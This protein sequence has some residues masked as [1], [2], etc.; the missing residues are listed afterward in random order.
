[1]PELKPTRA[2]GVRPR[3][4]L[5]VIALIVVV[6]ALVALVLLR[7]QGGVKLAGFSRESTATVSYAGKFPGPDDA[8]LLNPLGITVRGTTLYVAESD[9]ARIRVFGLQGEARGSIAVPVKPGAPTAYPSDITTLG[10]DRL[11][12]VDNSGARVVVLD[13]DPKARKSLVAVLGEG[14]AANAP[15]QPT[16]IAVDGETIYVADAG[17]LSIKAYGADGAYQR[18]ISRDTSG[19]IGFIGGLAVAGKMLYATD[20]NS[21]TVRGFDI[22][23]G[24]ARAPFPD[25][26]ALPRG[27]GVGLDGALF[28][29]DA[30]E[31]SVRLVATTGSRIDM[32]DGAVQGEGSLGSPRG[33]VWVPSSGRAYVTDAQNGCVSVFNVRHLD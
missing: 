1:M 32:I 29:A 6:A 7:G 30:F 26:F 14:D 24:A 15:Q 4:L 2:R 22:A 17:D 25:A 3:A 16:A 19:T 5:A 18:T 28:V 20:S 23:S 33:V 10:A 27:I 11:V 13:A 8:R 9:A 12:V 31:R 21:G